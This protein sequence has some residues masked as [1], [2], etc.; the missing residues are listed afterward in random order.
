MYLKLLKS[1]VTSSYPLYAVK[2]PPLSCGWVHAVG[3]SVGSPASRG[4]LFE[5]SGFLFH[6]TA[7]ASARD[8]LLH[9]KLSP[10]IL[11]WRGGGI[12]C[13]VGVLLSSFGPSSKDS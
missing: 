9:V 10:T 13:L 1:D 8:V 5:L 4:G 3:L 2:R 7:Y 11:P 6:N 12:Q